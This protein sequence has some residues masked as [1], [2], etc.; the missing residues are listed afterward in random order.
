VTFNGA[1]CNDEV[2]TV[3]A[4]NV[5]DTLGNTLASASA[6]MGLLIGHINGDGRVG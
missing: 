3:T 2:V 5:H 6:S 4:N 1:T